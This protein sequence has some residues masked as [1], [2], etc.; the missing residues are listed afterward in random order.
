MLSNSLDVFKQILIIFNV[1]RPEIYSLIVLQRKL[2]LMCECKTSHK[3]ET[4]ILAL[5]IDIGYSSSQQFVW[6]SA[7]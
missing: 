2:Y 7:I 6:Q 5:V 3:N 4:F 1:K